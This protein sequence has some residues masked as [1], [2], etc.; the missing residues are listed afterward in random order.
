M[1]D[2]RL[3]PVPKMVIITI[4]LLMTSVLS[5]ASDTRDG[6]DELC[7]R[8]GCSN[9]H[10]GEHFIQTVE[11]IS[12]EAP[13]SLEEEEEGE[14]TITIE[15]QVNT[16]KSQYRKFQWVD[17]VLTSV[18]GKTTILDDEK[19]IN[20]VD[21]GAGNRRTVKWTITGKEA[22]SDS[23]AV[24]IHA[25]NNHEST[26]MYNADDLDIDITAPPPDV[27]VISLTLPATDPVEGDLVMIT[28]LIENTGRQ[29][30]W[31]VELLVDDESE[32][33]LSVDLARDESRQLEW[34]WNSSGNAGD[35]TIKVT[36]SGVGDEENLQD[37]E[38]ESGIH[39]MTRPDLEVTSLTY[40]PQGPVDG[41]VVAVSSII[42]NRGEAAAGFNVTLFLDDHLN[43]IGHENITLQGNESVNVTFFWS[44][45]NDVG[46]H[47]LIVIADPEDRVNESDESNNEIIRL[48]TVH[49]PPILPDPSV[50]SDDIHFPEIIS[51][52]DEV[53][54]EVLIRNLGNSSVNITARV[55]VS[56]MEILI[57]KQVRL[58][59]Q[60]HEVRSLPVVWSTSSRMGNW[61]ISVELF[62]ME[63]G[64]ERKSNNHA[65]RPITVHDRPDPAITSL[66]W[67]PI[68][69]LYNTSLTVNTTLVNLGGVEVVFNSTLTL[70]NRSLVTRV[71]IPAGG[72][73]TLSRALTYL[74][75]DLLEHDIDSSTPWERNLT[76]NH[77]EAL[78]ES[79]VS[80]DLSI[81]SFRL[82]KPPGYFG[83]RLLLEAI[84][85]NKG[86]QEGSGELKFSR[87]GERMKT[88]EVIIPS[89]SNITFGVD[90]I[91]FPGSH[92]F[93]ATLTVPEIDPGGS[94]EYRKEIEFDPKG[95]EITL[96]SMVLSPS[97]PRA[98]EEVNIHVMVVNS[99]DTSSNVTITLE[100]DG[101][102][103]SA[104]KLEVAGSTS[105]SHNFIWSAVQG[106][107][108]IQVSIT[109]VDNGAE[110][111]TKDIERVIVIPGAEDDETDPQFIAFMVLLTLAFLGSGIA[112][113]H[114]I[115]K[116]VVK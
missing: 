92:V 35:R 57:L 68:N 24:D 6:R 12:F 64:D 103:R 84:V 70:G 101:D 61:S 110:I 96:A 89:Q 88:F 79:F 107:H 71:Q 34:E 4:I 50:H 45:S 90:W 63:P 42:G 5:T 8:D 29:A 3:N 48:I 85:Q 15:N 62:D 94:S 78:I 77:A 73:I 7:H 10:G 21:R 2:S 56:G 112:V 53:Q 55:M 9:H 27:T 46:D 86:S 30:V 44:S 91:P 40:D 41:E 36:A 82:W 104:K 39:V 114:Q 32:D 111:G 113:V 95:P 97:D 66:S 59:M 37:N 98:G 26:D 108:M 81:T 51:E 99:G 54:L 115:R 87:S 100:V 52:G 18:N 80:Q 13:T 105:S 20:N 1:R 31:D 58:R 11:I 23:L 33:V 74:G 83:N 14:V 19:R 22:G 72:N 38:R 106:E 17:F 75:A 76:N 49:E 65:S 25:R 47:Q 69:P 93:V 116:G 28:A 16:G 43:P 109:A 102:L 67:F 60:A